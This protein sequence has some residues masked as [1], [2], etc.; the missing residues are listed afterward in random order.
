[1]PGR[2]P[3][4]HQ[5]GGPYVQPAVSTDEATSILF[6]PRGSAWLRSPVYHRPATRASPLNGSPLDVQMSDLER[7]DW[8]RTIKSA[9][10]GGLLGFVA[11]VFGSVALLTFGPRSHGDAIVFFIVPPFG[12]LCGLVLGPVLAWRR[13][14]RND[15]LRR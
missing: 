2:R 14:K 6:Q 8:L 15:P 3:V 9:G 7:A 11:G 13:W 10:A 5:C 12:L 4:Q 1:M